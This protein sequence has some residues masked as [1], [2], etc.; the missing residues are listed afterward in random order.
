MF[1]LPD[2]KLNSKEEEENTVVY[3]FR[4]HERKFKA[5][6]LQATTPRLQTTMIR[7]ENKKKGKVCPD[8]KMELKLK[9][10]KGTLICITT[11]L[12]KYIKNEK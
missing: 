11:Q 9:S 3:Y 10:I 12:D 8:P 7:K 2:G 1:L 4:S 5:V 6:L